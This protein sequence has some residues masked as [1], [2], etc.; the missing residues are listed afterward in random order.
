MLSEISQSPRTDTCDSTYVRCLEQTN[1]WNQERGWGYWAL[2]GGGEPVFNGDRA[3]VWE[4]GRVLEV[5]AG[6]A[7]RGEPTQCRG[8]VHSKWFRW[9]VP[10]PACGVLIAGGQLSRL[11]GSN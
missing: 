1:P 11:V 2:V 4:N 8:A 9:V 10:V 3:S 6:D 7:A 5:E